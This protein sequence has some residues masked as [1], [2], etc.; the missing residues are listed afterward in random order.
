MKIL[1]VYN[2]KAGNGKAGRCVTD[3]MNEFKKRGIHADL[4]ETSFSGHAVDLVKDKDLSVYDAVVAAGGDGTIFEVVNGYYSNPRKNK[5]P[6]GI[7]PVGTG[8]AFVRD[9]ELKTGDWKTAID[10]IESGKIRPVDVGKF[11]INEIDYYFLNIIGIGFVADVNK[12]AQKLKI[13]GN[14]SY[15]IGVIYKLVFLKNY[16]VSL[17]LDGRKIER[18]N[19]FIE[20]SNTRYTSNFLMA[21]TAETDDGLLDI[22]LLNKTSRRRMLGA[23]PKIFTGDHVKME[24]VETFKAK[25]ILIDTEVPKELTP[26]GEMFGK[27]PL[28]IEC[29]HKDIEVF[30][31]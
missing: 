7:L 4:L 12:V 22:T 11:T 29:L 18:E 31:R 8:N 10:I 13:F 23:F 24:E 28:E 25:R 14:L 17:E 20:V 9:M 6:F 1:L 3:V 30:W 19:I 21:P 5:P 15:S 26:D 2:P 16:K 27:S